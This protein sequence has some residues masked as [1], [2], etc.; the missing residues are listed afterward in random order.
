[1]KT[2]QPLPS[3]PCIEPMYRLFWNIEMHHLLQKCS[4]PCISYAKGYS[5]RSSC[6]SRRC[7]CEDVATSSCGKPSERK[8][9][10]LITTI[11]VFYGHKYV[12][13]NDYAVSFT[14]QINPPLRNPPKLN[15]EKKKSSSSVYIQASSVSTNLSQDLTILLEITNPKK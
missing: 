5:I 14:H 1:M 13:F 10:T 11:K 6:L 8:E 15:T 7:R 3:S 9:F 12:Y 2:C 4:E